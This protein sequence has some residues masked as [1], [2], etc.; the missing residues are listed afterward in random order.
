MHSVGIRKERKKKLE[1]L[2]S[3]EQKKLQE[4]IKL[5]EWKLLLARRHLPPIRLPAGQLSR[6]EVPAAGPRWS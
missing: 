4:K 3:E 2:Q 1:K 5:E 6:A